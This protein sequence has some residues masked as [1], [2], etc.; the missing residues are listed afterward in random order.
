[1]A[2]RGDKRIRSWLGLY[3][4]MF[5]CCAAA[6]A[7]MLRVYGRTLIW[8][9]DGMKQ[10][11][12]V[13]GYVGQAVRDLLA[14]KGWRMMD[15]SLGQGMDVL[16][17]CTYYGYTDPLSLIGAFFSGQGVEI[18]YMLTDALRAYLAGIACGLYV[19]KAGVKDDW[20]AA[21]AC[22][23]YVSCGYFARM[24]G[25][26]PYFLNG[27]LYLP[28]LLLAVERV[29]SNR[30]W[31]M[32]TLVTA[33]ML[34]VNFYFAYINTVIA[35]VYIVVRLI[36]RAGERRIAGTARDGF[37]L[38]G[39]YLLG[40]A[41]S[42]VV[43]LPV[44][45]V[46][47]A[48]SRLG[49]VAGYRG[50][51]LHFA[52]DVYVRMAL[53]AFSPWRS[54]GYFLYMNYAPPAL[55][56]L[57]ALWTLK[58]RRPRQV[59][60]ALI[61]CLLAASVPMAG[62]IMNGTAYVS[63]RWS[64]GMALF[65]AL[66]CG[67]GLPSLLSKRGPRQTVV[68]AL[69]LAYAAGLVWLNLRYGDKKQLLAPALIAAMAL[70][71]LTRRF[72][73][74][75]RMGRGRVR[76]L[77]AALLTVCCVAYVLIGYLPRG[78]GYIMEEKETGLYDEVAGAGAGHLIRDAGGEPYRVGQGMYD[79]PNAMLL[80]Y[81]GT[82]Y[83]WSLVDGENSAYYQKLNLPS[84]STTYHLYNLGGSAEMNAVAAVKYFVQQEGENYVVPEGYAPSQTL[85]LPGGKT[86]QVYENSL[87]L[88]M[89]YAFDAAMTEADYDALPVEDKLRA[90]TQRAI[91]AAEDAG[92]VPAAA[93]EGGATTLEWRLA[94]TRD[95]ELTDGMLRG[96]E[97]GRITLAFD[98]P[99]D[100]ETYL[101]LSGLEETDLR[102]VELG[103]LIV[104]SEGGRVIGNVPHPLD[105]FYFPKMDQAFCLG[106]GALK[107][108]DIVFGLEKAY[109]CADIRVVSLPLAEYRAAAAARRAE[110]MTDIT[111]GNDRLTGRITVS[112]ER[113]LQIAVPYSDGW[114]AWV[115][116]AETPVFRCGGLYMGLALSA[117]T[118]EVELR[119]VT[120]G[121][122]AGAAVSLCALVLTVSL[123]LAGWIKKQSERD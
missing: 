5:L 58:G 113:I 107:S 38:L 65:V 24:I 86:A 12:T 81:R 64:Y 54:P 44:A 1:M 90:L 72:A 34:W 115:D 36:A 71:L 35:V 30:R 62:Y 22:M 33:V 6:V 103:W 117:G 11:Y 73:G 101:I 79:D 25:C 41:L 100:S 76:A 27:A 23:V 2:N 61:L 7:V 120:P 14:G 37:T 77:T 26:H 74:D 52:R 92:S 28:L 3:S 83:Y 85:S 119:Y 40:A 31:L 82:S 60:I 97:G 70:L 17:T 123:A 110:G 9:L 80:G 51:M 39:G 109:K 8:Y 84:Q 16:V 99:E 116:G 48:N 114:R 56:G 121:L 118:H 55:F 50:D 47:L 32:Y 112:G 67:L 98:A 46:Y 4:L 111:L 18:A 59:R 15:F 29:L 20:G 91:V 13:I 95:A 69:A 78:Y 102:R 10:H 53:Y 108:C 45:R 63:E 66:G 96:K 93:L 87:A 106:A 19:R 21:C 57:M 122:K 43:F 94:G 49:V 104:E 42:A 105:N 68:A 88:P 75:R 89:G